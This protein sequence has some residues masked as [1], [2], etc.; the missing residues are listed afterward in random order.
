MLLLDS[1]GQ[2]L[3]GTTD[4]TRTVAL[5]TPEPEQRRQFTLVLKG[6]IQ[7]SRTAFPP[8]TKG[9]QL[10]VLARQPLWEQRLDYGH[11]TGH[12]IGSY[13]NVHEGPQAISPT[14]GWE[15]ALEPGMILSLEP[16]CYREGRYGIRIENLAH[17]VPASGGFLRF[18]T[19]TLCPID[20][21]LIDDVLLT[22]EETAWL[23]DYHRRVWEALSPDLD[24][25]T[26]IWLEKAVKPL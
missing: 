18:E 5:G 10:D 4:V 9:G 1:G 16:G 13:L 11:G 6:L 8:G 21:K 23:N 7:L 15:A 26:R 22:E 24:G 17:I 25:G 2:Y 12:G 20:T 3:D 14:S 19:L